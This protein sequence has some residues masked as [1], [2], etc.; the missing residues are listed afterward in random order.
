MIGESSAPCVL[1]NRAVP[2]LSLFLVEPRYSCNISL[3]DPSTQPLK[4]ER[5]LKIERD[6]LE[7]PWRYAFALN[8]F[9]AKT[10]QL[11]QAQPENSSLE[12]SHRRRNKVE[13]NGCH[14]RV[15]QS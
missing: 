4:M 8:S 14:E 7:I 3:I 15:R 5:Q 12:S 6:P 11:L 9:P 1:D 13:E 2:R 10:N